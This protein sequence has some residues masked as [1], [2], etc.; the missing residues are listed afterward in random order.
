MSQMSASKR[1]HVYLGDKMDNVSR[2][3]DI[4]WIKGER[5]KAK[6]NLNPKIKK[7]SQM[8]CSTIYK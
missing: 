5:K 8:D 3:S 1:L 7:T 6:T 2:F 4:F